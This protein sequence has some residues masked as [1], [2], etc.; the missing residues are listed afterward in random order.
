MNC[1]VCDS[2]RTK[3][4]FDDKDYFTCLDCDCIFRSN[5]PE[6]TIHTSRS[7]L[8]QKLGITISKRFRD[9][10]TLFARKSNLLTI[11]IILCIFDP[12]LFMTYQQKMY[13]IVFII[14][15]VWIFFK[16]NLS[17]NSKIAVWIDT[18]IT[19]AVAMPFIP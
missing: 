5:L 11:P 18:E 8:K 4:W 19:N 12:S 6:N 13:Q 1:K 15:Y 10:G 14:I 17:I 9:S 3:V 7:S 2:E 16:T